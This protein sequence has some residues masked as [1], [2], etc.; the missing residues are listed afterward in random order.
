M[1]RGERLSRV[2]KRTSYLLGRAYP[3]S[4]EVAKS[5]TQDLILLNTT[6]LQFSACLISY[7]KAGIS[8]W[9]GGDIKNIPMWEDLK[10]YRAPCPSRSNTCHLLRLVL[11]NP[12]KAVPSSRGLFSVPTIDLI[13]SRAQ[14]GP[15]G[16]TQKLRRRLLYWNI[17]VFFFLFTRRK[18]PVLREYVCEPLK[19]MTLFSTVLNVSTSVSLKRSWIW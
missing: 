15:T 8:I 2:S 10:L 6:Q 3:F 12:S 9:K 1:F 5:Q 17:T 16:Q 14:P 19:E 11:W 13:Y 18:I 7:L 4:A